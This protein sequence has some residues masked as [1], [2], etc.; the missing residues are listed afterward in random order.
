MSHPNHETSQVRRPDESSGDHSPADGR[1]VV[2]FN[3]RGISI[4]W[5]WIFGVA[6]LWM[7]GGAGAH[8]GIFGGIPA[9]ITKVLETQ[10]KAIDEH[11]KALNDHHEQ[12]A[13]QAQQLNSL[14]T[15]V[16]ELKTVLHDLDRRIPR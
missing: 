6:P 1:P 15:D 14:V 7:L 2:K 8:Q 11:G 9:E 12:Q 3:K 10:G 5:V 13:L 4:P 16:H